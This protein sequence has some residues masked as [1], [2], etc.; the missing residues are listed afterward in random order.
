[1]FLRF[2]V[3]A[4]VSGTMY[5]DPKQWADIR[6]LILE[7]GYTRRGLA[8]DTGINRKTIRKMLLSPQPPHP[9]P[10]SKGTEEELLQAARHFSVRCNTLASD[11]RRSLYL[12]AR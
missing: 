12:W 5:R 7:E 3:S 10:P 4:S 1:M 2:L 8:R 9:A 6:R 11:R